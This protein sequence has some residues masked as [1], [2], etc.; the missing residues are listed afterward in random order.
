MSYFGVGVYFLSI[1]WLISLFLCWVS[2]RTGHYIGKIAIV[3]AICITLILVSLPRGVEIES[4]AGNFY[5]KT[6]G[7]RVA[8]LLLLLMSAIAG[9]V[10]CFVHVCLT[11]VET[12]RIKKF[13]T[14]N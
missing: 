10:Y 14:I 7:P 13:G 4:S 3:I 11:P 2:V 9:S 12:R 1:I 6:Y 5:D 8:I